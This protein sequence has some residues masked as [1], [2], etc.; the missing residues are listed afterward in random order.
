MEPCKVC[1]GVARYILDDGSVVCTAHVT[2]ET[3]K[4]PTACRVFSATRAYDREH[5]GERVTEWIRANNVDVTDT[6][7]TQSSDN[8]F[9]CITIVTFYQER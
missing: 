2:D 4:Q 9:H 5:L 1:G 6:W 3:V 7:V 8:A